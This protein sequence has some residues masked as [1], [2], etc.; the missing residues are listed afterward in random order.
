MI[1]ADYC[2]L[3]TD[4]NARMSQRLFDLCRSIDDFDRKRDR[5]AFFGSIHATLNH[6]LY[7]DLAFMAGFTGDPAVVPALAVDV[8]DNF[9]DLWR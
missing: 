1:A 6:I 8:P 2:W 3:M 5:G 4:Y 9:D 7:G